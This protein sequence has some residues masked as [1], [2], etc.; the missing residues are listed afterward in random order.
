[1]QLQILIFFN[2][3]LYYRNFGLISHLPTQLDIIEVRSYRDVFITPFD[4]AI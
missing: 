4:F 2:L 3:K 1:M